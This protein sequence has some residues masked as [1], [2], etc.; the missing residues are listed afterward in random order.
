[1]VE[2]LCFAEQAL[3]ALDAGETDLAK[4]LLRAFTAAAR[5][6]SGER[7]GCGPRTER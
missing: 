3:M 1:V 4:D 5:G 7:A 6:A 2:L